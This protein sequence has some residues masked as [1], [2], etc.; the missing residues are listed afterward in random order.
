MPKRKSKIL[1]IDTNVILDFIADKDSNVIVLMKSVKSRGWRLR[2]STFAMIELAEYRKNEL[3]LWDQL[4]K[5]KSLNS[6]IKRIRNPRDNKKLKSHHFDQASDWLSGL[7]EKLPNMGFLDLDSP[8]N[9]NELGSWDLAHDISVYSNLNAKD[10]IHLATAVAAA[11][12]QDCDFFI[13]SDGDLY[14]E[15]S[16]IMK[17]VKLQNKLK[18]MKPKD[19]I[20]IYPPIKKKHKK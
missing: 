16:E 6:I 9:K 8:K 3:F 10:V 7:Q 19:F 12:N 18:I 14:K 2:T 11:Q 5:N 4:S 17:L 1:Y 20:E 15:S 13:T